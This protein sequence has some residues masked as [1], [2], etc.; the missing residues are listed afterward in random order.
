MNQWM[1]WDIGWSDAAMFRFP[2]VKEWANYTS[3]EG[4]LWVRIIGLWSFLIWAYM[5][6]EIK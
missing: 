4:M 1:L 6:D 5:L 3:V 2:G